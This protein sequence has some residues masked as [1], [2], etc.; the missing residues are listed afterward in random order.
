[1]IDDTE[2]ETKA[3]QQWREMQKRQS[4]ES[5]TIQAEHN[6]AWKELCAKHNAERDELNKLIK[7]IF[8][9]GASNE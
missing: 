6:Q 4:E 2:E 1:M 3:L 5:E 7:S 9:K 8:R